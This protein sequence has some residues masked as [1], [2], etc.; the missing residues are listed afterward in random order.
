M[1]RIPIKQP[2]HL[3]W[4]FETLRIMGYLPNDPTLRLLTPPMET[5]DPPF[6]TPL[7]P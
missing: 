7:Q 4:F 5:P 3:T 1:I 2:R 6:M